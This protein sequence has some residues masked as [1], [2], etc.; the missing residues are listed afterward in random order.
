MEAKDVLEAKD[1]NVVVIETSS[2]TNLRSTSSQL[3]SINSQI[4]INGKVRG[5]QNPS[6]RPDFLITH[7][8]SSD[9]LYIVTPE[10]FFPTIIG[11]SSYREEISNTIEI[12]FEKKVIVKIADILHFDSYF[13]Y[14]RVE[15][16]RVVSGSELK[17][18]NID[19]LYCNAKVAL[20]INDRKDIQVYEFNGIGA[21]NISLNGNRIKLTLKE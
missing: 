16:A 13:N 1:V 15:R 4:N 19:R 10:R 8:V 9:T 7:K 11:V 2:K 5:F 14:I 3:V 6:A 12:P 21:S 18:A 20:I 17:K